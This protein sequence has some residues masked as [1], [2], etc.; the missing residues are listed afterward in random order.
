MPIY[1]N[2]LQL[3]GRDAAK[4]YQ[5]WSQAY[6]TRVLQVQLGSVP[7][8][9]ISTAAAARRILAGNQAAT[10]SRPEMYTFHKVG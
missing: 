10:S 8:L 6:N 4:Q 7:I 2:L 9:V 1:G 3:S 5:E